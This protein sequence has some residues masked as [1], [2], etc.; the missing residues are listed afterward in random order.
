MIYRPLRRSEASQY[1][2]DKYGIQL[3]PV[4]LAK[5]AWDG[6]GPQFKH[7]GRF[8]L[9]DPKDLDAWA[10]SITSNVKNSTSNK[11]AE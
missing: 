5:K 8:P 11:G 2:S 1:L 4:T 6:T 9:Y 7:A 3:K 10:A